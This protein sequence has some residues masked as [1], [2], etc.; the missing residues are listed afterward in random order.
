MRVNNE[1]VN[2]FIFILLGIVILVLRFRKKYFLGKTNQPRTNV[3]YFSM[4]IV[5]CGCI[6]VGILLLIGVL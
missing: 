5:G 3:D 1:I 6:I 4:P 2:A